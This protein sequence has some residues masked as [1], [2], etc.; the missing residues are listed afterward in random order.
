MLEREDTP[1]YPSARLFRPPR[2]GEWVR[3]CS[4]VAAALRELVERRGVEAA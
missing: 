2:I 4:Q 3:V 1:W